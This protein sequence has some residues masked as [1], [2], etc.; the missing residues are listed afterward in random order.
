MTTGFTGPEVPDLAF[1]HVL[2]NS[3]RQYDVVAI[4]AAR[5]S[6]AAR[7]RGSGSR[8]VTC[9]HV[10]LLASV[11]LLLFVFVVVRTLLSLSHFGRTCS[12]CHQHGTSMKFF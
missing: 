10:S 1:V 4:R 12:L 2:G 6:K 5:Q 7:N 3:G 9:L 11:S 8:P